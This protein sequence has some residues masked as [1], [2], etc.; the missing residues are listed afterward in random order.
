MG[1]EEKITPELKVD[2]VGGFEP[3]AYAILSLY[4]EGVKPQDLAGFDSEIIPKRFKYARS[5]DRRAV[6]ALNARPK[7]KAKIQEMEAEVMEVQDE[8][9][10]P[11]VSQ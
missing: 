11:A 2:I 3:S 4:R 1:M 10:S 6:N 5:D 9:K 8:K 7:L